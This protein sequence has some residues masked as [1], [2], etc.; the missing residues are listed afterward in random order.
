[1]ETYILSEAR[2]K[3]DNNLAVNMYGMCVYRHV[4][5][6]RAAELAAGWKKLRL[7]RRKNCG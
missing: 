5:D 2:I 1:L 4:L 7:S 6:P 3:S